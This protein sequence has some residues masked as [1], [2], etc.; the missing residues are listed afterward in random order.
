MVTNANTISAASGWMN[1]GFLT[2]NMCACECMGR[3]WPL[4]WITS[5]T[6]FYEVGRQASDSTSIYPNEI[7]GI[8]SNMREIW[9]PSKV[10]LGHA[11][12]RSS[13]F[14]S[15]ESSRAS[16]IISAV[17]FISHLVLGR[18]AAGWQRQ[19]VQLGGAEET[20]TSWSWHRS[21]SPSPSS[22]SANNGLW[23]VP[24]VTAIF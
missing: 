23:R 2:D 15:L 4:Y 9:I 3:K 16:V 11:L 14:Y 12:A 5:V 20:T 19:R 24:G 13:R 7:R 6:R 8:K 10:G 17:I 18:R 21:S 22:S 1:R